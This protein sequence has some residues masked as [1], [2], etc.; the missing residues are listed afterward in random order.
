LPM[1]FPPERNRAGGTYRFSKAAPSSPCPARLASAARL[2]CRLTGRG[3]ASTPPLRLRDVADLTRNLDGVANMHIVGEVMSLTC[4]SCNGLSAPG[5]SVV[6]SVAAAREQAAWISA[7]RSAYSVAYFPGDV[8]QQFAAPG[9]TGRVEALCA[10]PSTWDRARLRVLD[11]TRARRH[12]SPAVSG[13]GTGS[14]GGATGINRRSFVG[15]ETHRL[16]APPRR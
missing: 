16:H 8:V 1:S 6:E 10:R 2:V 5:E 4:V 3:R 13:R 14:S 9:R 7:A 11:A 15:A 12:V